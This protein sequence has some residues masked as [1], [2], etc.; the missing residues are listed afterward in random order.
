MAGPVFGLLVGNGQFCGHDTAAAMQPR[1]LRRFPPEWFRGAWHGISPLASV[2]RRSRDPHRE[3]RGGGNADRVCRP[4]RVGR[5]ESPAGAASASARL[6]RTPCQPPARRAAERPEPRTAG[7]CRRE[8]QLR[9]GA[10]P[11]PGTIPC[12]SSFLAAPEHP[13]RRGLRWLAKAALLLCRLQGFAFH[14]SRFTLSHVAETGTD[15]NA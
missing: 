4:K 7:G 2:S 15:V 5:A 13:Q 3:C 10:E 8:W 9:A 12:L 11:V 14:V 1:K 6:I